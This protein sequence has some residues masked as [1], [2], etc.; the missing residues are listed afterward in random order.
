MS[1]KN[2]VTS[3]GDAYSEA[4][5][6]IIAR[7]DGKQ[8]SLLTPFSMLN[9]KGVDGIPWQSHFVI[10]A[11]SGVG[12]TLIKDQ[13]LQGA[14]AL[15]P[16][17]NIRVLDFSFEMPLQA[18]GYRGIQAEIKQ[19]KETLLSTGGNKI[20]KNSLQRIKII[21]EKARTLPWDI[22]D[23]QLTL[24][25]MENVILEYINEYNKKNDLRLI[26]SID[27]S[28]LIKKDKG[29][30][31]HGVINE[32]GELITKLRKKYPIIVFTLSQLNR[33]I[34]E[35]YRKIPGKADNY[36]QTSDIST[37]DALLQHADFLMILNRPSDFNI[38]HYGPEP[39]KVIVPENG[40]YVAAHIL[41]NRSGDHG[42]MHLEAN[43]QNYEFNEVEPNYLVTVEKSKS[44]FDI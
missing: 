26:I 16:Y 32:Y 8:P 44:N 29:Q 20:D 31:T 5:D 30:T 14:F 25:Q 43:Y 21:V 24:K 36:P 11:R 2:Y 7:R 1:I 18:T 13:L 41:K 19:A 3:I 42:I 17:D 35:A 28:L 4:Y 27:H 15:N 6:Y 9:D 33:N 10:G 39:Y 38:F 34:E 23:E 40:S 37:A 12:K 22:V